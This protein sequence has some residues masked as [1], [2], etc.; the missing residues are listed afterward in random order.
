MVGCFILVSWGGFFYVLVVF[1]FGLDV[2]VE[3]GY[4][5]LWQFVDEFDVVCVEVVVVGVEC[6]L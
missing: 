6:F 2:V 3:L 1:E 4:V 5:F